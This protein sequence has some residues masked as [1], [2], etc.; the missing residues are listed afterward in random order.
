MD[1]GGTEPSVCSE[2]CLTVCVDGREV[3]DIREEVLHMQEEEDDRL[4]VA[5]PEIKPADKVCY[6]C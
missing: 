2:M 3:S 1:L 5:L 6:V 4:A